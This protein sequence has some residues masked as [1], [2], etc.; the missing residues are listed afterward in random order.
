MISGGFDKK[1][2]ENGQFDN[3]KLDALQIWRKL[4][5]GEK[6]FTKSTIVEINL[7]KSTIC[8]NISDEGQFDEYK[9]AEKIIWR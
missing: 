6:I 2:F 8:R 1:Q 9:F 7:T 4:Q 3:F 5:F